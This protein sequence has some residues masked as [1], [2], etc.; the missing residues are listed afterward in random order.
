MEL[1]YKQIAIRQAISSDAALLASWWNDG[2]IMAHAGFPMGLG[3]TEQEVS[4]TLES[5]NLIL[6]FNDYPIGEMN[7]RRINS[8]TAEIGVKICVSS[9]QNKGIGKIALSMLIEELF[10][11][12]YTQICLDTNLNNIRAQHV[13]ELLGF[14]KLRTNYNSWK[15]QLGLWESS[16]DYILTK[17]DFHNYVKKE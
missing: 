8:N 14:H 5:G 1:H 13:Y 7:Y 9:F 3:I 10:R 2:S 11:N 6:L 16:V 12:A 4:A 17:S 15:N